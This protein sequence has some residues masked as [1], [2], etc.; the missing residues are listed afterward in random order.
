MPLEQDTSGDQSP[1]RQ[2]GDKHKRTHPYA[3]VE[4]QYVP[5][6]HGTQ[7]EEEE[8]AADSDGMAQM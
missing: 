7:T 5:A 8:P 6:G 3:P 4:P 2:R 1:H